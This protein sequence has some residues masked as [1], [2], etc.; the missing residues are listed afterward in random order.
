MARDRF[1]MV[2]FETW[3]RPSLCL[4]SYRN[5]LLL[6]SKS[7]WISITCNMK[8]LNRYRFFGDFTK[9][10]KLLRYVTFKVWNEL[11]P[12]MLNSCYDQLPI[13]VC[14]A[15]PTIPCLRKWCWRSQC[16]RQPPMDLGWT[17]NPKAANYF[18]GQP[19][20]AVWPG[21]VS[22]ING[23]LSLM[24]MNQEILRSQA[25][26][27]RVGHSGPICTMKQRK[28]REK[29]KERPIEQDHMTSER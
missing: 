9:I 24:I 22:R 15:L 28:I 11:A 1:L 16:T 19:P 8:S 23:K 10:V 2:L 21:S 26:P 18:P 7:L 13:P 4:Y 25:A 5:Q 20:A 14:A 3:I 6:F 27:V 17:P 12:E 29:K